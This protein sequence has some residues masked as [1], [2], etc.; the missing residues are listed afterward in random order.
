[1]IETDRLWMM[2]CIDTD[3]IR[4]F[5][6]KI[7][8]HQYFVVG[9]NDANENSEDRIC[10]KSS[11]SSRERSLFTCCGAQL[12]ISL[13]VRQEHCSVGQRIIL[14]KFAVQINDCWIAEQNS[15][16]VVLIDIAF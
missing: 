13:Y 3:E 5:I 9:G 11:M 10:V 16:E 1:M 14:V 2:T 6:A 12:R 15:K 7:I 8:A 4:P